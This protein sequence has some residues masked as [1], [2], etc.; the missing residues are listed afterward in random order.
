MKT[1]KTQLAAM[2]RY[3]LKNK[4]SMLAKNKE[5][6]KN[7]PEKFLSLRLKSFGISATEYYRI[8]DSQK[9]VCAICLEKCKTGRRLGVDHK[10]GSNPV[11]V[12]GLL[13]NHCNHG[14]GKF[15]DSP[16][17]L[18]RAARYLENNN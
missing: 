8:L 14:I 15:F 6:K 1:S 17:L 3:Y 5:W 16:S 11:L 2:K 12:R 9:G 10:H 13:C 18:M 4:G 7:N